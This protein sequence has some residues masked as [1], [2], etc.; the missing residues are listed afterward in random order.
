M[1]KTLKQLATGLAHSAQPGALPD[2]QISA[3]VTDNRRV[4]PGALFCA[5]PGVTVDGHRFIRDAVDRGAVAIVCERA[6]PD[7][8]VPQ[9]IVPNG[10]VAFAS[11]CAAWHE[12]PSRQIKI[13]GITGTDGKTSTSNILHHI[14]RAAGHNSG[15]I[16]TVNAVIGDTTLDTGL[17]V[18]TP[19]ADVLHGLLARMRDAGTTHCVLEVTS[20][21]LAQHRV[22]GVD[23]D[24]AVV[25][26]ITHEHLDLHGTR[27]T[28]RAAKARLFEMAPLHV[29]N[30]DDDYSFSHLAR[31][32]S[33]R[34]VFYS[35]EVQPSGSFEDW[36]LFSP[37]ADFV[38]G[39]AEIF[40]F[41]TC[42]RIALPVKTQLIGSFNVSNILAAAGAALAL[43]IAPVH[44]QAGVASVT[45]ISGRMEKITAGQDYLA[46]VDFAHTPNALDNC[47]HAL[48]E[49]TPGR[50][51]VAFG[52][53]GARDVAKRPMMG[54]IADALAD[55]IVLTSEDPRHESFDVICDQICAGFENRP[56]SA[57]L[58]IANRGEALLAACAMAR[59]GDTVVACGKGH[60][61]SLCFGGTEFAWD[62]R[63]AMRAAISG[64]ALAIG[65]A[66]TA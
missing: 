34:R 5:Y 44:I 20:H 22:D 7:L 26:N 51:I 41:R 33:T 16:T 37:R 43:G 66:L 30:V 59:P 53:A 50:L 12:H 54:K 3:I 32:R 27:E 21:A 31:L 42:E 1:S 14:L 57:A 29:L 38:T 46:V 19:D 28:Y 23:F 13:V 2:L 55:E 24:V 8:P 6:Q 39:R 62:E 48:K 52:C 18:T 9:L 61:Q 10:R 63:A 65:E 35:R 49:I 15:L 56:A 47:L 36:W 40:G 4:T 25:T 17:H 45:G 58:R 11:L 60:E 64:T